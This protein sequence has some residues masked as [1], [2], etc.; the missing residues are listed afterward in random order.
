[1]LSPGKAP[2]LFLERRNF[3]DRTQE[4][5]LLPAGGPAL[6]GA[7]R[8]AG[9]LWLPLL[10]VPHGLGLCVH[11]PG[12]AG[13][14][15]HLRR[16]EPVGRPV[17]RLP[18]QAALCGG[19]GGGACSS[20]PSARG[21]TWPWEC[22]F[23]KGCPATATGQLPG[24]GGGG[25]QRRRGGGRPLPGAVQDRPLP[26]GRARLHRPH[27][28]GVAHGGG[29]RPPAHQHPLRHPSDR[30]RA[31]CVPLSGVGVP[32]DGAVRAPLHPPLQPC[33]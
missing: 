17:H 31:G 1:M 29:R 30:R 10:P 32:S 21:S 3:Y 13:E 24:L 20:T 15:R 5:L 7:G 16:V 28:Q 33:R 19:R 9:Y 2:F 27:R 11:H 8:H 12:R 23:S 26:H 22:Q 6:V 25:P 18:G 14:D 4:L